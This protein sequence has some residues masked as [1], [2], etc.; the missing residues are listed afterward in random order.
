MAFIRKCYF[1]IIY[2]PSSNIEGSHN[3]TVLFVHLI[4]MNH[5]VCHKKKKSRASMSPRG[6][7][8]SYQWQD[9]TVLRLEKNSSRWLD[10]ALILSLGFLYIF[11]KWSS[12]PH[13]FFSLPIFFFLLIVFVCFHL[14]L[15]ST[16]CH[17]LLS[18]SD[19]KH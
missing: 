5:Y 18:L 9:S 12:M 13:I 7:W 17:H 3:L 10:Q 15:N 6:I 11:S 1:K 4:P 8:R 2:I 19:V 14:S 16:S